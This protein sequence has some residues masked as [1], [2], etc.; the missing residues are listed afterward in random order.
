MR[1]WPIKKTGKSWQRWPAIVGNC[2]EG[3]AGQRE[4]QIKQ[5]LGAVAKLGI[6]DV[7]QGVTQQV[8]REH[9]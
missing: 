1:A 8:P 3:N 6:Q 4:A 5:F 2:T 9:H 7:A